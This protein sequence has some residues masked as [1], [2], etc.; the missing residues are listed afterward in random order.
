[1]K[2]NPMKPDTGNKGN[3]AQA[4][5]TAL[6]DAACSVCGDTWKWPGTSNCYSCE[7]EKA[8]YHERSNAAIYGEYAAALVFSPNVSV[9]LPDSGTKNHG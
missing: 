2:N 5:L 7:E 8:Y 3:S 6:D 1:M 9:D 4:A